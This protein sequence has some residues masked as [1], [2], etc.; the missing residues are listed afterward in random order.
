ML[1]RKSE[2]RFS[3]RERQIMDIIYRNGSASVGDVIEA[4]PDPPGYSAVRTLLRILEEKGHL[5]HTKQGPRYLYR[6]TR[7]RRSAAREALKRAV[8][9]FFDGSTTQAVAALLDVSDGDLSE[10]EFDELTSLIDRA[11]GEGR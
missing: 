3:R 7:S 4:L 6:P 2:D 5:K 11:R 9:T 1:R 10:E 8:T